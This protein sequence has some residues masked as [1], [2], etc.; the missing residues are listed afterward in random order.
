M[1]G[2][3]TSAS[4]KHTAQRTL[5]VQAGEEPGVERSEVTKHM[6]LEGRFVFQWGKEKNQQGEA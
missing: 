5:S 4:G 6:D 3:R 1:M 2:I